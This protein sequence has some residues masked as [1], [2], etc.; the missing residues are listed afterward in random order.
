MVPQSPPE[1]GTDRSAGKRRGDRGVSDLVGYVLMVGVILVGV[2][3]TA[4]VGVDHLESAQLTQNAQGIERAME[5][6]ENNV[7]EIQTARASVRTTSMSLSSGTLAF[8]TGPTSSSVTVNVSGTADSPTTYEMGNITY[9][10]D[11]GVVAYEGGGVFLR[12]RGGNAIT[13]ADP[14]VICNGESAIVSIV[15]LQ[16]AA[17]ERSFGGGNVEVVARENRSRLLFP[18][19][20]SGFGSVETSTG[21]NVTIDSAF[22]S[23]WDDYM[24]GGDQEWTTNAPVSDYRCE[25]S[26]GGTMPVY[27]RQT[28]VNMTAQG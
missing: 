5:L 24:L 2:G 10:F 21:V 7:D 18:S 25:P 6:L 19:S 15:T 28:V 26:G 1:P 27:V 20:R 22:P 12:T 8:R 3:L 13:R 9:D 4:T 14:T 16:G 11:G 17:S 23:A